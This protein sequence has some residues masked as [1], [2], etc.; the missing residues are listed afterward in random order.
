[1]AAAIGVPS[2][3]IIFTS[4]GTESNCLALNGY[5]VVER[6]VWCHAS[7]TGIPPNEIN[8]GTQE[9][10]KVRV[11][12]LVNHET[13]SINRNLKRPVGG[14]LHVDASQALGKV[15]FKDF[16]LSEVDTMTITA[17][18]MNGP[19]GIGALYV[20]DFRTLFPLGYGGKQEGGYR[21]GSENVPAIVGWGAALKLDRSRSQHKNIE[22]Y[23]AS[24]LETLGCTINKRGE[25][26][27][28]IVHAT[29]P[30][31]YNN[32]DVV[33]QLSVNYNIEIGTGSSC[34]S[35]EDNT[36]VYEVLGITP[37]PIK[38]S[39]RLSYDFLATIEQ[40]EKVIEAMRRVLHRNTD[41]RN[42]F[43]SGERLN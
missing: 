22:N 34:K 31:G 6:E 41:S 39:I 18:K 24:R 2:Q 21:P 26:S 23:L 15:S 14:R 16:D 29:L 19:L 1:L 4:G 32:V 33:T 37:A 25:T 27:G 40:A 28:F 7:T 8:R 35:S 17:H 30:E 42:H 12:D 13:G 43:A 3:N 20:R 36:T 10:P 11:V 9:R 38:R 5:Q